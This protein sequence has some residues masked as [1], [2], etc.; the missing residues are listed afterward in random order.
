MQQIEARDL[1]EGAVILGDDFRSA[2]VADLETRST[3]TVAVRLHSTGE[4]RRAGRSALYRPHHTVTLCTV[5]R[6]GWR[7]HHQDR[8]RTTGEGRGGIHT[9]T[10]LTPA[11]AVRKYWAAD[12]KHQVVARLVEEHSL[13]IYTP[14]NLDQLPAGGQPTP[15]PKAG[16]RFYRLYGH[17][18]SVLRT[19]DDVRQRLAGLADI[20]DREH[21]ERD[22][23][24]NRLA[25][26]HPIRNCPRCVRGTHDLKPLEVV[27]IRSEHEIQFSDLPQKWDYALT[28]AMAYARIIAPISNPN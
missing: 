21:G 22:A 19:G 23:R 2:T 6:V 20:H 11:Y 9:S 3:G 12:A 8:D 5:P 13:N 18:P 16:R 10:L 28:P 26:T 4:P 15:Q 14:I 7:I 27:I 24:D 17:G 1:Y 25:P